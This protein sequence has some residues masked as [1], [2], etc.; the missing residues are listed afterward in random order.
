M[1]NRISGFLA[2][3][4]AFVVAGISAISPS[5]RAASYAVS[6]SGSDTA[7]GLSGAP[8]RTIQRA[9]TTVKAGDVV[10]V[11]DGT[12]AGLACDG[13]SGTA[14]APIVFRSRNRWG[15]KVTS[16][17]PDSTEDFVQLSS[18]SY[19][20]LDGFEVSGAP[21]SGIAILGNQNDGSDA[22]GV[23]IQ[24]C[25]SH[26]NGGTSKAGR[27]DGVFSGFALDLTIQD[28]RIDMTGE[29]GIYVSNAA[30]NPAILRNDVSNTGNNC[31]Q[32]NADLSTG[33]D[34]LISNWRIEGNTVRNCN[35]SAGF[36]LDGAIHGV[37]RNNVI[38]NAT[39][40]GITLFKGDGAEASHDNLIVNNTV[41]NPTG[42]RSAIQVADGANNNVIFNNIF[43]SQATGLEVQTVTGLQHDYNLVSSYDGAT[44]SAHES[45]PA[46]AAA[47][48]ANAAGGDLRLAAPTPAV[49]IDK[50]TAA[51]GGMAAPTVDLL[52]AP[53]PAGAGYDIGAYEYGSVAPPTGGNGGSSGS[54]GRGGSGGSGGGTGSA[55]TSGNAG[56]GGSAGAGGSAGTSGGGGSSG[57]AGTTG[58]TGTAGSA[59]QMPGAASSGCG[60]RAAGPGT[61]LTS[62][63]ATPLFAAPIVVTILWRR[64]RRR[65]ATA[66]G[67]VARR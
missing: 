47:L 27:H 26:N 16:A 49:A 46:N 25:Y 57:N 65:R 23:I 21:R 39:G 7:S 60:C 19:V 5:A 14:A 34:G 13:V 22:R 31:I 62:S 10:T 59:G 40:A 1:R 24:N 32:I 52:G 33:G 63:L 42:S 56:T 18:C 12:Y 66:R 9:L 58:G 43:I 28:N 35:G 15:A 61:A 55:G 6:P 11:E 67:L 41:Y 4:T 44:A 2:A 3:L 17:T 50:G 53:R 37:A 45:T 48:F 64:R 30:D 54:G 8:W 29:H 36:N 20:T 38:Y 51:F